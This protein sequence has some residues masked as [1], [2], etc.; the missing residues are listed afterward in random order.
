LA[1]FAD[2]KSKAMFFVDAMPME[3]KF[4]ISRDEFEAI[5]TRYISA[6]EF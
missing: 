2:I 6:C 3:A 4:K 1:T 5:P